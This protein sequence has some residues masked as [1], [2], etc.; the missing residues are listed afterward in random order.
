[1]T[2]EEI[3][4][5]VTLAYDSRAS[6]ITFKRTSSSDVKSRAATERAAAMT[7]EAPYAEFYAL[8]FIQVKILYIPALLQNSLENVLLKDKQII[9]LVKVM[10]FSISVNLD[11]KDILELLI[12]DI[13]LLLDKEIVVLILVIY[14]INAEYMEVVQ[15]FQLLLVTLVDHGLPLLK[16]CSLIQLYKI[17]I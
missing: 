3:N 8:D 2:T 7:I 14:S 11:G 12:Q 16:L 9:S 17:K 5:G 13:L 15:I 4:D 10:Q 1:M 6:S